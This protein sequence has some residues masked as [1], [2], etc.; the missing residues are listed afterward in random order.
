MTT[1]AVT[2]ATGFVGGHLLEALRADG[3]AVRALTRREQPPREGVDWIAGALERPD[4]LRRLVTG[5]DAVIHVAA[6]I[7][8]RRPAE[9]H[10]ANAH[11]TAALAEAVA[12]ESATARFVYVSSLAAREPHLSAYGASKLGGEQAL[13]AALPAGRRTIVRAPAVY[14]PG[15][16]EILKLLAAARRGLL[17]APGSPANRVSMIFAPDLAGLLASQAASGEAAA[18]ILEPDDG[19]ERGYDYRELAV[20]LGRVLGRR[21]RAVRVP[22]AILQLLAIAAEGKAALTGRATILSRGKARE[23][24]HPDWVS[25][26]EARPAMP[27]PPVDLATGLA[28]TVA[29]ARIHRLL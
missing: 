28:E 8:A 11:G 21:V 22:P 19:A 7:K 9:F 5:A 29:W 16:A 14:G 18:R 3:V 1:V 4:S 2:G 17:P 24:A 26:P 27:H 15:D 10:Q 25:R 20:H 13:E 23:L 12:A 6:L